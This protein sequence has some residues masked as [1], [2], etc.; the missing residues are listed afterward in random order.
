M[1]IVKDRVN[2]DFDLSR[3]TKHVQKRRGRWD[4]Y[5]QVKDIG[6]AYDMFQVDKNHPNGDEI[7]VITDTG[8]ILIFNQR[9][10]KFITVLHARSNQL[11]RYY[12][13]LNEQ[14]PSEIFSIGYKNDE[15]NSI[16]GL[17]KI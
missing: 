8:Y 17:N 13:N 5:L 15:L 1:M 11:K 10:K 12:T 2:F 16:L 7:H 4:S 9:T 14:I 3:V 6:E